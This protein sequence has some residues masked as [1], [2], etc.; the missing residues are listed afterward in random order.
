VTRENG[1]DSGERSARSMKDDQWKPLTS[2]EKKIVFAVVIITGI[3]LGLWIALIVFS[4]PTP[5]HGLV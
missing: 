3:V 1:I 5:G 2:R 4:M